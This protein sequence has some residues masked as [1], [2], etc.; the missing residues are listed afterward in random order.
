[1]SI[2]ISVP[3]ISIHAPTRGATFP[4]SVQ[5]RHS[6]ISIHAPTR[7]ATTCIFRVLTGSSFQSTLPQEERPGIWQQVHDF[8]VFQSTLPQEE[9]P[10]DSASATI[11]TIFQSTLPQE[12]RRRTDGAADPGIYFNPRSHKRSDLSSGRSARALFHF[13]P[14]SHKRSDLGNRNAKFYLQISIHAPTRGATNS[15]RF[16]S[17]FLLFQ[18][19]LPQE[20][21]RETYNIVRD[22]C[23][24]S[25]HAPTRGATCKCDKPGNLTRISIH[26]PTRG[27]TMFDETYIAKIEFQSTLP[28][29]ERHN[30]PYSMYPSYGF[31]STLPQEERQQF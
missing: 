11:Y 29:E 15:L 6:K 9:R 19:T 13:N 28:Q 17:S 8:F 25:I 5:Y 23:R 1:M 10:K 14:R 18:S 27:A 24:I 2:A 7:G 20:E 21:R 4:Q 31:Q 3:V 30:N 12:E 26:A 22:I 16:S